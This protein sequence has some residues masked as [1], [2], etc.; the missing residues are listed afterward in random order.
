MTLLT[1]VENEKLACALHK[2]TPKQQKVVE[3]AFWEGLKQREIA[4]L[5]HCSRSAV[6]NVISRADEKTCGRTQQ[7]TPKQGGAGC[8]AFAFGLFPVLEIHI[9]TQRLF[10]ITLAQR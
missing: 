4:Q 2:L 7:I 1:L 9:G 5:M 3:L 10:F 6:A 8:T